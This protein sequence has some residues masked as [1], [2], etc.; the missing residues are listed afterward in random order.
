[1]GETRRERLAEF[2]A[3]NP[4]VGVVGLP[5]GSWLRAEGAVVTVEGAYAAVLFGGPAGAAAE[6]APGAALP[7]WLE[8]RSDL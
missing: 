2:V 7:A 8:R 5:E 3:A 1:M 4:G 6:V